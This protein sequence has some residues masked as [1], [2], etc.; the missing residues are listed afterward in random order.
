MSLLNSMNS[1]T[2][3]GHL[4]S[5]RLVFFFVLSTKHIIQI[6]SC[7][8]DILSSWNMA[9]YNSFLQSIPSL[10]M[11]S[12][13]K[14][15]FP[16]SSYFIQAVNPYTLWRLVWTTTSMDLIFPWLQIHFLER[17]PFYFLKEYVVKYSDD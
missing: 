4:Y 14:H 15:T 11:P 9:A 1:V 17:E 2:L 8:I 7:I 12:L 3:C 16:V 6:K 10:V 5:T 13:P